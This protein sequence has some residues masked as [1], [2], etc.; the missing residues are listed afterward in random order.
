MRK[1]STEACACTPHTDAL[2]HD[3]FASNARRQP[4]P[5]CD[6]THSAVSVASSSHI[7]YR[8]HRIGASH[9]PEAGCDS[10][11]RAMSVASNMNMCQFSSGVQA[12][13]ASSNARREPS[14]GQHVLLWHGGAGRL[15]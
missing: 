2:G 3:I 14:P 4:C 12:T 11:H 6:G 15:A 5:G 7:V 9:A 13:T 10:T 1:H 8:E